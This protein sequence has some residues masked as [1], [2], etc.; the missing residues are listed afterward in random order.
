M[1]GSD[2]LCR[3]FGDSRSRND[4]VVLMAFATPLISD[5][6]RSIMAASRG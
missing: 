1:R 4:V 6:T 5:D 2:A 3:S